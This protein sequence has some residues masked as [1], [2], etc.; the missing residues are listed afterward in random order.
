MSDY[1]NSFSLEGEDLILESL[2]RDSPKSTYFDIGCSHPIII[3][4]T[5]KFYLK[6]WNGLACDGRS[7][8][9][10]LWDFHRPR[11]LFKSC[12]LGEKKAELY[13]YEFPDSTLN[14]IDPSAAFRYSSRFKK[15]EVKKSKREIYSGS[16]LWLN[17]FSIPPTLVSIDCEGSDLNVL[18]GLIS[19]SFRPAC[20]VIETKLF[21]FAKPFDSEIVKFMYSNNYIMISKTPLDAF[22]IDPFNQIFEWIPSKMLGT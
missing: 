16:E 21:N 17:Y 2:L 18:R 19:N 22:F 6:N 1:N 15:D 4:N 7:E 11:D 12:L 20:L 10:K 13:Y 8:L 5:Y 9:Q 14:T 3:N